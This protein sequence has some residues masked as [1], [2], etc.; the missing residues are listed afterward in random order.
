MNLYEDPAHPLSCAR[1]LVYAVLFSAC[2]LLAA[3]LGVLLFSL[4]GRAAP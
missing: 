3:L 2:V 1:G 4:I